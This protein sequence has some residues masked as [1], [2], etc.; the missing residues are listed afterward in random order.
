MPLATLDPGALAAFRAG[1]WRMRLSNIQDD[2]RA[3]GACEDAAS[4]PKH[5]PPYRPCAPQVSPAP[6]LNTTQDAHSGKK[7]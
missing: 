5:D 7:E 6:A 3:A 4:E 1:V 2:V